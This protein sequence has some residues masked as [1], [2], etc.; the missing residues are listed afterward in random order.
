[1]NHTYRLEA[2]VDA[3]PG[4]EHDLERRMR[5]WL[6]ANGLKVEGAPVAFRIFP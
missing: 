3:E 4:S 5:E 2:L 6:E 1:V